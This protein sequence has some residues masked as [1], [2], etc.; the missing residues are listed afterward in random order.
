MYR[1]RPGIEAY[2][3]TIINVLK[4]VEAVVDNV[5]QYPLVLVSTL[6]N[7]AQVGHNIWQQILVVLWQTPKLTLSAFHLLLNMNPGKKDSGLV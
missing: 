7:P 5:L 1:G 6:A 4:H 3:L 2:P